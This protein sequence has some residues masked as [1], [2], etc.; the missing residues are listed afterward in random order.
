VVGV[1]KYPL[2]MNLPFS[3]TNPA[4]MLALKAKAS[5]TMLGIK[6]V[7]RYIRP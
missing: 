5:I 1:N 6:V 3:G 2:L 7:P 4:R